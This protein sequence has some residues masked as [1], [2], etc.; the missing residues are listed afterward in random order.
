MR[1]RGSTMGHLIND[2]VTAEYPP[3]HRHSGR[4]VLMEVLTRLRRSD[5]AYELA[6]QTPTRRLGYMVEPR[7]TTLWSCGKR[8]PVRR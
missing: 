3:I 6:T 1:K 4:E 5:L 2:I 8:R 7:A